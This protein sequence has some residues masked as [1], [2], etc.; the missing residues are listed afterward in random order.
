MS[1]AFVLGNG[2]SRLQLDLIKLKPFGKIFGCNALYREFAPDYL[3]S[4]DQPMLQEITNSGYHKTNAVW[5]TQRNQNKFPG[6]NVLVPSK[7]WSS[8]PT[9]LHFA[10]TLGFKRIYIVGFDYSGVKGKVNNV[11]A[12]SKN[13]KKS[14]DTA[15]YYG[16]WLKQTEQVIKENTKIRF[17]RVVLPGISLIPKELERYKNVNHITCNNFNDLLLKGDL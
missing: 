16:N 14:A 15:T 13:Y 4:V 1:I 5:T 17:I 7:G 2:K 8:G 3:I 12:D 10:T 11:Y 9:A 6:V